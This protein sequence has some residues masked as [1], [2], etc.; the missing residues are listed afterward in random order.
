MSGF[1]GFSKESVDFYIDLARNNSKSWFAERKSEFEKSVMDPAKDFVY[2]MGNLLKRLTPKIIAD[3]RVNGSI[4]RPYRDT[5]FS[6]DKSPYKTHLGIFFWEGSAAKM[7]CSGFYFHLEPPTLFL[8][9]GM[10]CFSRSRLELYRNS[11]VDSDLGPKLVKAVEGVSKHSGYL[12]GGKHYKKLPRGYAA[13]GRLAELLLHNGLYAMT[14][15]DI[16]PELYSTDLLEY[17]FF[18]FQKMA[19]IHQWLTEMTNTPDAIP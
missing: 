11:V 9:A 12:V 3:P 19:P 5:R 7:E 18:G 17:C 10:H 2:S 15:T 1:T 14:E 13:E 16:P 8:A 6:K 4:F